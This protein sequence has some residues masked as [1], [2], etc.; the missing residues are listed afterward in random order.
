MDL[1]SGFGILAVILTLSALLAGIVERAPLSFPMLFLGIG[2][3]LGPRFVDVL[4]LGPHAPALEI[5]ATLTLALVL[6]LDGINLELAGK[7][8]DWLA[9]VLALGPGTLVTAG[10]IGLGAT[11]LLDLDLLPA[12]ALGVVLSST[13]PVVLRDVV[14]DARVP[15]SI[16]HALSVEAGMNDIVVL[17]AL[18]VLLA[19]ITRDIAGPAEWLSFVARIFVLGPAVGFVVGAV[20]SWLIER[21]DAAFGI[22]REYQSLYG[23]GLVLGA[24]GAGVAVGG[25][26]FLAAFAA[27]ASITALNRTLC[28]CFLEFGHAAAEMT[29]LLAFVLFGAVLSTLTDAVAPLPSLA[30]GIVAI[31]VARPLVIAALL[32]LRPVAMSRSAR[33]FIAWFGPRGLNSLLFALILVQRGVPGGERL[34]AAT[35]AVVVI[36]VVL[37]GAS[38]TPAAAAYARR[39]QRETLE[40]ERASTATELFR[41]SPDDAPRMSTE[42]LASRLAGPSP[43]IVIDVRSRS[44][45]GPDPSPIPGSI[46]VPPDEVAEWGQEHL[47]ERAVVLACT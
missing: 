26:G 30:L 8:R 35:G 37:H 36:S 38:A 41:L 31:L 5:V 17:P 22:R 25:D 20:G 47:P 13:D 39:L 46:R 32:S 33:V 6:F 24:Y 43:P 10:V 42:E 27:G 18:L 45:A 4:R 34:L 28:D 1:L 19:L 21:A 12:L 23:L 11:W 3:L 29:M 2:L 40:E 14:R 7:R 9:P 16:R 44:R 15:G